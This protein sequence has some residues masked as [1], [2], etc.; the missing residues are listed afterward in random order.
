MKDVQFPSTWGFFGEGTETTVHG[1]PKHCQKL[2]QPPR[3]LIGG[4]PLIN[5]CLSI[6]CLRGSD[7]Q[8]DG[9]EPVLW[10]VR[11]RVLSGLSRRVT[12]QGKLSLQRSRPTS[13]KSQILPDPLDDE[14][15]QH[16]SLSFVAYQHKKKKSISTNSQRGP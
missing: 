12:A 15:P 4:E 13:D 14:S 7:S 1:W 3:A 8:K 5:G 16:L 6:G 11:G 2:Y 9:R 10:W